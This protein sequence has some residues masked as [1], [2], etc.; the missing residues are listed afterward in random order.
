MCFVN[1][2]D[3]TGADFYRCVDMM[4][5]RLGANPLVLQLPIGSESGYKGIV[6]LVKMKAVVW[7][8]ETLGA[9]FREEDIPVELVDDASI[10][11]EELVEAAVEQDDKVMEAYAD[12]DEP[13]EATLKKVRRKGTIAGQTGSGVERHG[14]QE[15]GYSAAARRR[16]RFM[17]LRP[18]SR[19]LGA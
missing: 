10:Y 6:D 17:R 2:M 13:D 7:D 12:G 18:M 11:R 3:W 9:S 8:E 14:F 4:S 5:D 15:Q 1:K 19:P 16:G